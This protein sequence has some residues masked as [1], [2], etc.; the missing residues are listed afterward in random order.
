MNAATGLDNFL[1]SSAPAAGGPFEQLKIAVGV[2]KCSDRPTSDVPLDA[3]GFPFLVVIE[4]EFGSFYDDGNAVAEFVFESAAGAD[5]LLGRDAIN[6]DILIRRNRIRMSELRPIF[7][8]LW[9]CGTWE[10]PGSFAG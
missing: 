7:R 6:S 5:D 9:V 4:D 3:D 8:R 2:S 10:L 1:A